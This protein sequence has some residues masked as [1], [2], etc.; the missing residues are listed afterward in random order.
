[1]T[2][3]SFQSDLFKQ[4]PSHNCPHPP[5]NKQICMHEPFVPTPG[6][7]HQSFPLLNRHSTPASHDLA[8]EIFPFN[9]RLLFRALFMDSSL[10]IDPPFKWI[11]SERK[12]P[13]NLFSQKQKKHCASLRRPKFS[14][15]EF[16]RARKHSS[17]LKAS[18]VRK[19]FLVHCKKCFTWPGGREWSNT[20]FRL[21]IY[22][23][24]VR[25]ACQFHK[26]LLL[27]RSRF[28]FAK[29]LRAVCDE[30]ER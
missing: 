28:N 22:S 24:W 8:S 7:L 9:S 13:R 19:N 18:G 29:L 26:I 15:K 16:P 25:Q 10:P 14:F 4:L 5:L 27:I 17:D 20:F 3:T 1:M 11:A 21:I 12:S 30:R 2:A 23:V 6:I